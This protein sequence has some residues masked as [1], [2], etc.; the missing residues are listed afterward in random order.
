MS[1]SKYK[2]M[3]ISN[4]TILYDRTFLSFMPYRACKPKIKG[5]TYSLTRMIKKKTKHNLE[6]DPEASKNFFA[7]AHSHMLLL[8]H[9]K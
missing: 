7:N 5:T 2:R 8:W 4:C 6:T 3:K 1:P 9:G